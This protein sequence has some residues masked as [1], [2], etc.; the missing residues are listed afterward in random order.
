MRRNIRIG[1]QKSRT[2][3][4]RIN[5]NNEKWLKREKNKESACVHHLHVYFEEF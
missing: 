1:R 2:K 5:E 3:R 4:M